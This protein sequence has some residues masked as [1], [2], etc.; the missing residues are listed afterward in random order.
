MLLS[1]LVSG[2]VFLVSLVCFAMTTTLIVNLAVALDPRRFRILEERGD[3][4]DRFAGHGDGPF[5]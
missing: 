3:H 1:L 2:G 4:D 5:D